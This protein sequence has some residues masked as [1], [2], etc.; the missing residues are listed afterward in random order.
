MNMDCP[1]VSG[2]SIIVLLIDMHEVVR[3][4][5]ISDNDHGNAVGRGHGQLL[6]QLGH[7]RN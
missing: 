7:G 4:L 2:K 5:K 1:F 6:L 3:K